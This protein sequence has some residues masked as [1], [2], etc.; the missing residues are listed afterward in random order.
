MAGAIGED[1]DNASATASTVP[2]GLRD[3]RRLLR[4]APRHRRSTT[5]VVARLACIRISRKRGP[6]GLCRG[7][8]DVA[9]PPS[10]AS[11]R[12]ESDTQPKMPPCA[13]IIS[14]AT[15]WNSGK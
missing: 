1:G 13:L 6:R 7:S 3:M 4:R 14:S 10:A 12:V 11:A 8:L 5:T 9:Y 15:R 2:K